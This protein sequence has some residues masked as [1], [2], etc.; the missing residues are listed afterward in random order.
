MHFDL[1]WITSRPIAHRGLHD[2]QNGIIENSLS[3]IRAAV[4]NGFNIEV[5]L[6]PARD[7]TPMVF[8][9]FW[10]NRLT[11]M[12]GAINML[13]AAQLQETRLTGSGD[14]IP[15]LTQLL[16]TVQGRTGLVIEL[17]GI[18]G[19]D[20]GFV[21]EVGRILKSYAGPA[22]IMSFDHWLLRDARRD[23][24]DLPLGL[25]AGG[26]QGKQSIHEAIA[27]EVKP[28]FLSYSLRDLDCPF[29]AS[30]RAS[31]KPVISWTVRSPNDAS[32][33]ALYADQITFEGFDP[34]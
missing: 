11:G 5:D 14:T 33:S 4:A 6:H 27:A 19:A 26:D 7:G 3:A 10:L 20:A 22:A 13:D 32:R 25:T 31:G 8:H 21:S 30:F 16:D 2:R 29:V 23:A 34:K 9:D 15:T 12:E 1:S 17:K 18:E 24:P 28:D